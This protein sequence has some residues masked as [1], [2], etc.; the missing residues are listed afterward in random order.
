MVDCLLNPGVCSSQ[1]IAYYPTIKLFSAGVSR[2]LFPTNL[3]LD[4]AHI[5]QWLQ[6]LSPTDGNT[7][8]AL[9][10]LPLK[11]A[12]TAAESKS[13]TT[14]T[15]EPDPFDLIS[16]ELVSNWIMVRFLH[17]SFISILRRPCLNP[18]FLFRTS[19]SPTR[20]RLQLLCM[21]LESSTVFFVAV[22]AR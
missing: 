14:S 10:A 21:R 18:V 6:S 9:P 13:S 7:P 20:Y 19:G 17:S 16:F 2:G 12:G 1:Q 8:Y 11:A 3:M 4:A 22:C 5:L 15:S